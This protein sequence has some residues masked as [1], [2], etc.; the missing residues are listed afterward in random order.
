MWRAAHGVDHQH[1][2]GV[3]VTFGPGVQRHAPPAGGRLLDRAGRHRRERIG[4]RVD[5]VPRYAEREGLITVDSEHRREASETTR[6]QPIPQ[7]A[8]V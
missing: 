3:D 5:I 2:P 4:A 7:I 8:T 6:G 1:L